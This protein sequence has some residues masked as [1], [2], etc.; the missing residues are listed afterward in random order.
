MS[1]D[2]HLNIVLISRRLCRRVGRRF[3]CRGVDLDGDVS[4]FVTT[5]QILVRIDPLT[6]D[7]HLL[8]HEQIRGSVPVFWK[9]PPS[10]RLNPKIVCDD[11]ALLSNEKRAASYRHLD[12]CLGTFGETVCVN[13][14]DSKGSQ[15]SLGEAF[16]K[17]VEGRD[18]PRLL[19]VWFDYHKETAGM[20]LNRL[21]DLLAATHKRL[22]SHGYTHVVLKCSPSEAK[23]PYGEY[24]E[25]VIMNTQQGIMRTN[26][27]DCLDRTNVV[28]SVFA[29]WILLRQIRDLGL[30]PSESLLST[31]ADER[32]TPSK[33]WRSDVPDQATEATPGQEPLVNAW[34]SIPGLNR[35]GE[36]SYR[37]LWA[38]NADA[39]S[40]HYSG[41]NALKTDVT[42]HGIRSMEGQLLDGYN[43]LQRYFINNFG[44]GVTQ[45][46]YNVFLRPDLLDTSAGNA[47]LERKKNWAVSNGLQTL[48]WWTLMRMLE[49]VSIVCALV[50]IFPSTL[51]TM[52]GL[53]SLGGSIAASLT[54]YA[55]LL[56]PAFVAH[57][58]GPVFKGVSLHQTPAGV[59]LAV[60]TLLLSFVGLFIGYLWLHARFGLKPPFAKSRLLAL[61]VV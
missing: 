27:V 59:A 35:C 46:C 20:Q 43:S 50:A 61:R 12:K 41:T 6:G 1:K 33:W 52:V 39:I 26:C 54:C 37:C 42:R 32:T 18:H 21:S 58:I 25:R 34:E 5:E 14:V 4:N 10:Y 13:L 28:Q 2:S 31:D 9:Q 29:R 51:W 53:V 36:D 40:N 23:S 55:L 57:G 47:Q 16:K 49:F 45:D 22:K 24:E 8:T 3:L 19:F 60:G 30:L 56:V 15:K 38:D 7:T 44:D 11:D 17:L 48:R